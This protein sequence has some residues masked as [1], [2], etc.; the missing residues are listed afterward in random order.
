MKMSKLPLS[1]AITLLYSVCAQLLCWRGFHLNTSIVLYLIYLIY[2]GYGLKHLLQKHTAVGG[3][4]NVLNS[5][6]TAQM[7]V[8]M[9]WVQGHLPSLA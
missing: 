4:V 8:D 9:N 2:I 1:H 3:F 6:Y 7:D 5:M